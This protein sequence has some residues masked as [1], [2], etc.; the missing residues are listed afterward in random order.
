MKFKIGRASDLE[1][2]DYRT[3]ET[4]EELRDYVINQNERNKSCVIYWD[5]MELLIY[6]D[7]IE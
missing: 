3:F 5:N 6:D 4:I 7:W 2:I 1:F